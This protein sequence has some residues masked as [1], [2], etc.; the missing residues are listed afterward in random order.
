MPLLYFGLRITSQPEITLR[1]QGVMGSSAG[2][3]SGDGSFLR[4][5]N[6]EGVLRCVQAWMCSQPCWAGASLQEA[7]VHPWTAVGKGVNLGCRL[8]SLLAD[9]N[10]F[11]MPQLYLRSSHQCGLITVYGL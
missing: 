6:V 10:Q 2:S 11:R 7:D 5:L 1:T 8:P 3:T 4:P 9:R